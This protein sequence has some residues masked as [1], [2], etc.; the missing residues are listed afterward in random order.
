MNLFS[1]IP[2][3]ISG[4]FVAIFCNTFKISFAVGIR[5]E[6]CCILLLIDL[7]ILSGSVVQQI[8]NESWL[9]LSKSVKIDSNAALEQL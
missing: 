8:N 6:N 7:G 3:R 9:V 4:S 1:L 2:F 5:N